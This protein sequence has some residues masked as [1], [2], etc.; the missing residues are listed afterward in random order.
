RIIVKA[1][2]QVDGN[3]ERR[4]LGVY[5]LGYQILN[6]DGSPQTD[7][8]WTITFDRLPPPEAVRLVYADGSRSGATG[9]TI[10][11]YIVTNF[12]S[13]DEYREDFLDTAVL[14]GGNYTLRVN[15]ADYFGNIASKD[16]AIEVIK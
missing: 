9:E 7:V 15:A 1:F 13:G 8:R 2:D 14:N 11:R 12:V 16:I 5:R 10:F 3:S 6:S 4:R